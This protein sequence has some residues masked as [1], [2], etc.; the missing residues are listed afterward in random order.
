MTWGPVVGQV[1]AWLASLGLTGAFAAAT[2]W[3]LFQWLGKRWVEDHFSKELEA[4]KAER[5][6]ELEKLRSEYGRETE[7][8]K[9][10]LNR[11]AD[12]ASRFHLRE[13]EVLP[14]AWGLMNKAHGLASHAIA[15]FQQHPDLNRMGKTQFEDWLEQ[16]ELEKYQKE[17]LSAASDKNTRYMTFRNWKQISDADKAAVDFANYVILQGVFIE[18]ALGSKMMDAA[19]KIR[20]ALISRTMVEDLKGQSYVAGQTNFWEQ[21]YK[22]IEAVTP[23]V[24]E[25]KE[26]VRNRLSNIQLAPA[27]SD[28]TIIEAN[29]GN[30]PTVDQG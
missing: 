26:G 18:E 8:L 28:A 17:E 12:R 4:F 20:G 10:D 27:S 9:A 16:A 3:A 5:Q 25:V 21:S 19:T 24:L 23:M 29:E 11:F 6:I 2:A 7:R 1:G 13:Y 22:E 30:A 15:S 14:E